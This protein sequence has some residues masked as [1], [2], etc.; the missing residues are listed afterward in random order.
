M[1]EWKER[2]RRVSG[3]WAM[4]IG[5][6]VLRVGVLLVVIVSIFNVAMRVR[7]RSEAGRIAADT[8]F[9]R[10]FQSVDYVGRGDLGVLLFH[11][12]HGTP[13]DFKFVMAALRERHIHFHAPMLGGDRPSPATALGF[14]DA[15]LARYARVGYERL[16]KRC[17]RIV[18]VGFSM[19]GVQ[20][21]D[22]AGRFDVEGLVVVAP[23]YRIAKR[24]YLPP[25][26]EAWC[27][28]LAP[29]VPLVPKAIPAA[30]NDP[31]AAKDYRD[32]R[33]VSVPAAVA[34][35]DYSPQV[36]ARADKITA[37]VLCLLSGQDIVVDNAA[38]QSAVESFASERKR[39]VWYHDAAHVIL[40]DYG[41]EQAT[42]AILDFVAEFQAGEERS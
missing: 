41:R 30:I 27:R 11:G 17:N 28:V 21:T 31:N 14:T 8:P 7:A 13:E 12:I 24:W 20:A 36:L 2:W 1:G 29:V 4:R 34:L 35:A 16:A 25:S 32:L 5:R 6:W 10:A 19:G 22:V 18:V 39:I 40:W 38:A 42:A 33:T 15:T 9:G 3:H 37:P 26:I 23:G